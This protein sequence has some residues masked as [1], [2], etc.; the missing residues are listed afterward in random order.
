LKFHDQARISYCF[1]VT[2]RQ[3]YYLTKPEIPP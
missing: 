2:Q 3:L 1:F